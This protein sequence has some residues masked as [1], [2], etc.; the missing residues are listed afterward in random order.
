MRIVC[1]IYVSTAPCHLV[2]KIMVRA[3]R[4]MRIV[5]QNLRRRHVLRLHRLALSLHRVVQRRIFNACTG[6]AA[7]HRRCRLVHLV[8]RKLET[9]YGIERR[10][11]H[12]MGVGVHRKSGRN[13]VLLWMIRTGCQ[14]DHI[15]SIYQRTQTNRLQIKIVISNIETQE[16]RGKVLFIINKSLKSESWR[17]RFSP[18]PPTHTLSSLQRLKSHFPITWL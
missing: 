3:G 5:A 17:S 9:A 7:D 12:G 11:L 14:G 1:Y 16:K 8:L 4:R 2:R 13:G 15:R 10:R 6:A 18:P